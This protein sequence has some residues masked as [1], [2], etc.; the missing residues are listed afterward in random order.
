MINWL[1]KI[2]YK[3]EI[4][5]N[6]VIVGE[7]TQT[8]KSNRFLICLF[9]GFL[10]FIATYCSICGVLDAFEIEFNKPVIFAAFV[11][12]SLYVSFLYFNKIIFYIFYIVLFIA[13][14]VELARYYMAAN[15]GFQAII[16]IIF[17]DYSDYFA[18][19]SIREGYETITNRYFTVTVAALFLGAFTAIL[20][21][22]TI[23]GYMNAF[24]T[25]LVTFP[26]IEI[27]LFIHKIPAA[28]YLFGLLFVYTCV[29]FLQFSRH[30]R[31]QVKGKRTHEFMRIKTKR[32]DRY[33]YQ[34]DIPVFL[35]SFGLSF[36]IALVIIVLLKAPLNMPIS[37]IPGNAIHKQTQEYVKILVQN[38][39][40]GFFDAYASTGG[41]SGGRLGG[42][43]QVRPDF[44]T[45]LEVTFVPINYE[46]IYLKGYT[47]TNYQ[48]SG[49]YP[50][51]MDVTSIENERT[52]NFGNT[53]KMQVKE[54][55]VD[56]RF[57]YRPYFSSTDNL[58]YISVPDNTYQI[59]Y[60]PILSEADYEKYVEDDLLLND[61]YYNYVYDSCLTFPDNLKE[62]LDDTL[63][64]IDFIESDD[65]NE[66]RLNSAKAIY[67]YFYENFSYTMAPG[68]TA[69]KRDFVE[70]FLTHQKRGFCAHFASATVLLLRD[71]GIP[72]RYCEGYCIPISLIY[73]DAIM[74]D[75]YFDEWYSGK[76]DLEL[77]SV[78]EV[79]V[80]DSYAHA[81]V[82]IYLEGY[83]FVPFEA[84]I[85]SFDEEDTDLGFLTYNFFNV[86]TAN[87]LNFEEFGTT[88]N[89]NGGNGAGFN[90]NKIF[91]VFNFNTA[92]VRTTV[93]II[94]VV[95]IGAGLL[96]LLIRFL[97][98][99]IKLALY[100]KNND[101]Y[102]LVIYEYSKL[103]AMLKRKGYL[104]KNNPLPM[105]V[106]EAYDLYLAYYNNRHKKQKE[107]D[108]AAL[109]EHYEKVMYS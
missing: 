64:E 105:D 91:D 45:D 29:V 48:S 13:F 51:P 35:Y 5:D 40:G 109:F 85:P 39:V 98:I 90:I 95:F 6:K 106:K 89:P 108:T 63:K 10:V 81:W 1:D 31:M 46:T 23:S 24:E 82:E 73:D 103:S 96:F 3:K 9:K 41:L 62:V 16:N 8:K 20:L 54:V 4:S 68:R 27:A 102:H 60:N 25:A 32:E 84:T 17:E 49:W 37:K 43:A 69:Y 44:E 26:Y 94:F 52:Y 50:N 47:G 78:L 93:I 71:M 61:D 65:I 34:A 22:V 70:Y 100:R 11:F 56:S 57:D 58:K 2:I 72:A 30:S 99:R 19:A 38:G 66:Y 55:D 14:T 18:L 28:S 76:Q 59:T 104:K 86:I 101:E 88:Q 15:S 67:S 80:N 33:A 7:V 87:T 36:V 75:N 42:V 53:A 79:P 107:V 21:N 74:T 97:I 92:G 83:G 12:F 77:K